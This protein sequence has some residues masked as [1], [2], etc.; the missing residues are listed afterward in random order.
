M[1]Q[2]S[3]LPV[4]PQGPPARVAVQRAVRTYS[5]G[6]AA[7]LAIGM[8]IANIV[9][10]H[11]GFGVA[12][13]LANVAPM[14]IAAMASAPSIIARR[15]RHLD[16]SADRADERRLHR[17]AGPARA[18]RSRL[19]PDHPGPGARGRRAERPAHHGAAGP[20][21]R[22]H[23]RDVLQPP[24]RRPV[25]RAEPGLDQRQRMG[26][27]SRRVG[28]ADPRRRVHHRAA[29]AHLVQLAARPV[30]T[31]AVRRRKQRH[32]G[33]LQRRQRQRGAG[34]E[35]TGSAACSPGSAAWP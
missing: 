26:P 23:A 29:A 1:A 19:G 16:L 35:P 6:F 33:L 24:G 14:A 27:A 15:L 32:D 7:V 3:T 25:H 34:G 18:R 10:V 21:D 2:T 20:G 9:T 4:R 30:R 22:R 31:A 5:F 13:Q 11:G 8:L 28:R 17:L 12:D